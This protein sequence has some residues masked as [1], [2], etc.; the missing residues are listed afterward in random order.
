M[1]KTMFRKLL[2]AFL[3]GFVPIFLT[4]LVGVADKI[5]DAEPGSLNFSFVLALTLGI[6]MGALSAGIRAVIAIWT[7]FVPGDE[8][9]SPGPPDAVV[10][11]TEGTSTT[12]MNSESTA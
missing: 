12:A 1:G 4:G 3:T 2:I 6:L 5:G 8:I 11:T 9:H 7:N 10:V